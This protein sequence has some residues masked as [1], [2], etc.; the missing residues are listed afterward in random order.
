MTIY[1]SSL[2]RSTIILTSD[3][4]DLSVPLTE[5]LTIKMGDAAGTNKVSFLD[6]AG[7]EVASINSDGVASFM[8]SAFLGDDIYL[9]FGNTAATPDVKFGWNTAQTTDAWY[10]GT[11]G[12][13]NIVIADASNA[14][15]DF[16]HGNS[17]DSSLFLHSRNQSTTQ[18]IGLSHDATDAV[19][20]SGTGDI[21]LNSAGDTIKTVANKDNFLFNLPVS[22]ADAG[23]HVVALQLDGT[24]FISGTATGNGAGGIGATTTSLGV[25]AGTTNINTLVTFPTGQAITAGSYQMGRNADATN[26][27]NSNVP[28]GASYEWGIND[29]ALLT[30]SAAALTLASPIQIYA[31]S[32]GVMPNGFLYFDNVDAT[33]SGFYNGTSTG[34]MNFWLGTIHGRALVFSGGDTRGQDYD[35]ALQAQPTIYIQSINSPE[36]DN[37][38]WVKWYNDGSNSYHLTGIGG[39]RFGFEAIQANAI[40]T[41]TANPTTN[42][43]VVFTVNTGT[44]TGTTAAPGANQFQL[45]GTLALTLASLK[46]NWNLIAGTGVT[47]HVW[48]NTVVFEA[49][50]TGETANAYVTTETTDTDNVYLFQRTMVFTANPTTTS[51]VVFTVG[52]GTLTGVTGVPGANQFQLA[53]TLSETIDNL[54]MAYNLLA[55][56]VVAIKVAD[57]VYFDGGTT[58]VSVFTETTDTDGV[59][60]FTAATMHGGRAFS[61]FM[62]MQP[63]YQKLTKQGT[64]TA[65]TT[66]YAS[67]YLGLAASG[68]NT[69]TTVANDV[70]FRLQTAADTGATISGTLNLTHWRGGVQTSTPLSISSTGD[71]TS[72]DASND[73]NPIWTIGSSTAE[74]FSIQ[75]V[76]V[77][78]GQLL[79]Y[80]QFSTTEASATADRGKYVFGVDGTDIFS[81]V[82]AGIAVTGGMTL[83]GTIVGVTTALTG[84]VN[85]LLTISVPDQ[86]DTTN[87]GVGII[88]EADDGGTNTTGGVGGSITIRAG[89]SKGTDPHNG[90]DLILDTGALVGAARRGSLN[91]KYNNAD[92]GWIM[93]GGAG[94]TTIAMSGTD[95]DGAGAI[96]VAIG[97]Y[98]DLTNASALIA[99]FR[100]NMGTAGGTQKA[101]IDLDGK[102]IF[103]NGSIQVKR[104]VTNTANPPTDAELDTAFGDPT[105]VGSGFIGILDDADG[106]VNTYICWTTGTAGE[107]F[108]VQGVKAV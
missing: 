14:A 6:S 19:I 98:A 4:T 84:T 57:S 72:Y 26:V 95:A 90:G 96:G 86:G 39:H 52:T 58:G 17:T 94:G 106:G 35:H 43:G 81:I 21:V 40:I 87:N 27:L 24:S 107:Y 91:L 16:A 104:A 102:G 32:H 63:T 10:F 11:G 8:G 46:T 103:T 100:D 77:A 80:V 49:T 47:A 61:A 55:V 13:R 69:G 23:A 51:G 41:F 33:G 30:L 28:T 88:I 34:Q 48:G 74:K 62:D 70:E 29:V 1:N 20:I 54:V 92:F 101:A 38:Q 37:R 59:Y 31:Y 85:N 73:G 76:Y 97:A 2:V 75:T 56:G 60:S 44:L 42:L 45:L 82:D 22:G 68:W 9:G 65:G 71:L 64:A 5:D 25:A 93:P 3:V 105:V 67:Q 79:N 66:T 108:Y 99:S 89:D 18:Y 50:G 53:P 7:A 15:F 78:G 36:V 83:S 12:S